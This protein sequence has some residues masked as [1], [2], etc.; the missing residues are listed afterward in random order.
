MNKWI[1]IVGL[2]ALGSLIT[3]FSGYP[4]IGKLATPVA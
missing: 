3:A 1:K 2:I 4:K